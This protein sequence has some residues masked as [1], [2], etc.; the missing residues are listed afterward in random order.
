MKPLVCII[1]VT[2]SVLSHS[3]TAQVVINEFQYDDV[4]T[5]DR[6]FV[7]LY[8]PGPDPVAIGGWVVGGRD[9][10]TTNPSVTITEGTIL[11]PGGYYVIGNAGVLNVSQVVAANFL[12]NDQETIELS[13]GG[14]VIDALAY[15]T[16]KGVGFAAPVAAQVGTGIFGNHQGS[17][18]AGTPLN[19][20]VSFG[21]FV[22]GRDTNNNGRDFGLRP[23][24]PGTTNSPGGL[25]TSF[26]LPTPDSAATGSSLATT[27]GSFVNATVIDP[28][29]ADAFNPNA[30]T[31]PTGSSKAYVAWD[32]S[33]G[34]NGVTSLASYDSAQAG[35]SIQAYFDTRPL[36]VQTNGSG[37]EFTGSEITIYGIGSGDA[38]TNL[39]D[40][41][42]AV[43]LSAVT[44][45]AAESANG[46]TGLAWVYEKTSARTAG[47]AATQKLHLVNANDGGDSDVGGNTPLDWEIL[48][49]Y[50]LPETA[51]GEWYDLSIEIQP[52]GT[53]VALFDGLATPFAQAG[54]NS[55]A[56]NVGYRENLQIGSD[57]TP[58]SL[59]RPATFTVVPEPGALFLVGFGLLGLINRRQRAARS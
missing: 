13:N 16:N 33:G 40:L 19:A 49:T 46:F 11:A 45:P 56:F 36:P 27:A 52:D 30:I 32:P 51:S 23:A 18:L 59:M 43:G 48:V 37:V 22:D 15:E 55:G 17:D 57:G 42:G 29:V 26:Q 3:A 8:N 47:T 4:G 35:F 41:T 28:G 31:L 44:L 25:M 6:E 12:E 54:F 9:A 14:V 53:G 38:L 50:S 20:T 10:T 34:G 7:E 24:T 58:D 1:G 5:D 2:A 39:T 21:R